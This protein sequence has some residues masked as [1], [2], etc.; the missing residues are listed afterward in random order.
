LLGPTRVDSLFR[1]FYR[2]WLE[3][4]G[5][6][7]YHCFESKFVQA[8]RYEIIV[9]IADLSSTHDALNGF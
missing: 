8:Q 5:V 7:N 3:Q 9:A 4:I 1:T 2:F 6:L